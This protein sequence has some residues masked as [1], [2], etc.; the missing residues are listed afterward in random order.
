M[1]HPDQYNDRPVAERRRAERRMQELNAA[2]TVLS[3]PD[4]RRSYDLDLHRRLAT[5][6][7]RVT[8]NPAGSAAWRQ[9]PVRKRPPPVASAEEMEVR[10]LAKLIRPGPIA[11]LFVGLLALVVV[12]GFFGGGGDGTPAPSPITAPVEQPTGTPLG[13]IVVVPRAVEV[14]C[15]DHEAVVWAVVDA[16]ESCDPGLEPFYRDGLGGLFCAVRVQ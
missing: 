12:A 15:G 8:P 9:E 10:G 1:L 14:P 2:W 16:G 6:T 4:A 13:C 3:D 11:A 5:P 7:G